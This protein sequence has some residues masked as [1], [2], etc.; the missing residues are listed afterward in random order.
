[1]K[2][3]DCPGRI[4]PGHLIIKYLLLMKLVLILLLAT[5]FQAIAING[6]SQ[7]RINMEVTNISISAI[8]NRIQNKYEYRFF[9]TDELGL[10]SR[11]VDLL[12]KNATID[13]VMGQLLNLT[14][15]SYKKINKGLVVI[16]GQ[17]GVEA[18][19][20]VSGK[21]TDVHGGPLPGVSVIEKGTANGTSTNAD[22][23]FSLHVKDG[24]A[25][26][27]LSNV[28]YSDLEISVG[29][30]KSA[31]I[32][33]QTLENKLEN[34]VVVGYGTQKK[35][36]LTGSVATVSGE[37]LTKRQVVN[38]V[39]ALQG[40]L[41]GVNITQN[42]GQPGAESLNIQV[43]GLTTYSSAG[44]A[45]LVLINGVP[46]SLS[47]LNPNV[48]ESI[49]VLKDAASAAIYGSRAA[50]GVILVTTKTGTTN[51]KLLVSYSFITQFDKPTK[52]P[53]L[54]TNS[55]KYMELF[56]QAKTNSGATSQ[57]YPQSV[58]D[59][60]RD[61]SDPMRYPDADWAALMFRTAP[62]YMHTL[63]VSGGTRQTSYDFTMG[64]VNQEGTMRAF[65]YKK[66]NAM[67]NLVSEVNAN[68]KTG[69]NL[70]L[71]SGDQS[72]PRNGANDAFYQTLAHPPTALPWLPD[73]SGRF[74]YMTYPW[75]FVRPNQFAANQQ[76]SRNIDYALTAQIWTDI[77]LL[78]GL[79]WFT[80]GAVNVYANRYKEFSQ[81]VPL[82][83]YLDADNESLTSNIPGS[84]LT[85][86]MD[87]TIYKNLYSYLEY[88]KRILQHHF[89]VQAGYSQEQ[90]N[91][92]LLSGSRPKY[93]VGDALQELNAGD[94]TP[95]YNSGTSNAWSLQS[96]FGRVKY[97]FEGKYLLEGNLRYDGSSRLSPDNRWGIFP[98]LSAG[99]R[100]SEA[101]FM[102][103]LKESG[104]INEMKLRG[105][106]GKIGNQNIGLY[107]YQALL[108]VGGNYPFGSTLSTGAYQGALNNDMISWETTTMTD[109]GLDLNLWHHLSITFDWYKKVTTDILRTAQVTGVVGLTPPVVNSGAM[110][111][112]GIDFAISYSNRV[113]SGTLNG[114]SYSAGFN[115]SGFRNT[116]TTFGEQQDNGATLIKEGIPWNSFYLLQW[117]GIFQ[118]QAEVDAAPKQ[119]GET[120]QPGDLKFRDINGDQ[121]IDNKDRIIMT[122][123]IF[124]SYTYGL[125]LSGS[126]KGFDLYAF[127]Q[128]V[129]GLKGIFGYNRAPGLTPF[130]SG[131][132]P[133]Q[134]VADQAWTPENKSTTMPLLYFSDMAAS[135][136]VWNH[137]ST[138]LLKDMSYL[139][140]KQLQLGYTLPEALLQKAKL[141]G[142][143]VFAS[144]ENLFT[145]T[146]FMGVDPEKPAGSYLTYPQNKA[147]S[148]GVSVKF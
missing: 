33:M 148:L 30:I 93:S 45:P 139:R 26:L 115:I 5:C 18:E 99:W 69:I 8:L 3:S 51:S 60:Y 72:Q 7:T 138:F 58:I 88:E 13:E 49:S 38:P 135:A 91:Y 50:N 78:K 77:K 75:E 117:D 17:P 92:Y 89:S 147:V 81:T 84:G 39:A 73:G 121:V 12:A 10:N 120:T 67:L 122:N 47:D 118:S 71:K 142:V 106:W 34:I 134:E 54:V 20:E 6:V 55:V 131:V 80:K 90:E 82:F 76:L 146:K 59:L 1:M 112:K 68:I 103:K 123:G 56:N 98:S 79:H 41:P 11:K 35:V 128:G 36:N 61:P 143:R 48:I 95:Q 102:E 104:I 64:Y 37:A 46:G 133:L 124:P 44:S 83:A 107:P 66:Y 32:V 108:N 116:T 23:H 15:Y 9:Y 21:I 85:S 40:L 28:G 16:I 2:K 29:A 42:S 101:S 74:T 145:F 119:F 111:N 130:F 129:Q 136:K 109:L 105:S 127:F 62:T 43:R 25:T 114:F 141:T 14:G 144:G 65:N 70:G 97:D 110:T 100:L 125:N 63:S 140:V 4:M 52:L 87:Q 22:G 126:W 113:K 24:N 86:R 31:P 94:A 53:E 96:G 57:F 132:P 19:F 137:P 27:I